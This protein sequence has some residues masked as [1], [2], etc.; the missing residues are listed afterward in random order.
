MRMSPD[1]IRPVIGNRS[2]R[3]FF[4]ARHALSE[5]PRRKQSRGDLLSLIERIGFVQ[6]DSINTV[7]RAHDMILFARNQTYRP[8]HLKALLEQDRDL[9]EN[10]THDAAII[11]AQFFPYWRPRFTRSAGQIKTRW[12][13]WRR[14]GF[15][16]MLDTVLAQI[17]C[18]GPAMSRDLGGGEKKSNGA[19]RGKT[20]PE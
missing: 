19:S 8:D 11:P 7:A 17:E 12:T 13:A 16:E 10:W 14:P 4:L 3:N 5:N 9:F 1:T 15:L 6:V 20:A 2:A 18:N